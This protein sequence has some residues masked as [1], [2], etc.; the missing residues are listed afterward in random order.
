MMN[1]LLCHYFLTLFIAYRVSAVP[2]WHQGAGFFW[3]FPT[4]SCASLFAL[5]VS[6]EISAIYVE[7]RQVIQ[8]HLICS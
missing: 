4:D 5:L 6:V 1:H 7:Y 8:N 2:M 3:F